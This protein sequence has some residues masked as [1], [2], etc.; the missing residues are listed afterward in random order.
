M[1][2]RLALKSTDGMRKPV[3]RGCVGSGI[4]NHGNQATGMPS[5][6][7]DG[8]SSVTDALLA[9]VDHPGRLDLPADPA[10]LAVDAKS[11]RRIGRV[12]QNGGQLS[13]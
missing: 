6:S 2:P 9:V 11:A 10:A 7:S 13:A 3:A 4:Q 12:G 8:C 5:S 1:A